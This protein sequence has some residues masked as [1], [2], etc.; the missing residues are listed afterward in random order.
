V[1]SGERGVFVLNPWFVPVGLR[2]DYL[3]VVD[4]G[5]P[6][7]VSLFDAARVAWAPHSAFPGI[8]A[9]PEWIAGDPYSDDAGCF[10]GVDAFR[11]HVAILLAVTGWSVEE[12]VSALSPSEGGLP[13]M[14]FVS[15]NN[16]N[17]REVL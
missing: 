13:L 16:Q 2:T 9:F 14:N 11:Q 12:L 5:L 3:G 15:S 8:D 7:P 10:L 1:G 17:E 6:V 4:S